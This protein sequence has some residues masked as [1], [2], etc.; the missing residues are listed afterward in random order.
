MN[1][2]QTKICKYLGFVLRHHPE[3]IGIQPE[4]YGW[5]EIDALV[6]NANAAGKSITRELVLQVVE[7]DERKAFVISD[8]GQRIRAVVGNAN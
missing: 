4:A 6:A 7:L 2:R 5:V 3:A 8:D 1:R